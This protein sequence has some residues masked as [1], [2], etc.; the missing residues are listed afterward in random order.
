APYREPV[1]GGKAALYVENG[2]Y[3]Y[4]RDGEAPKPVGI[5]YNVEFSPDRTR[6]VTYGKTGP[7]QWVD[8]TTGETQQLDGPGYYASGVFDSW[9]PDSSLYLVQ[10]FRDN[11]LPGFHFFGRDGKP[12]WTWHEP[13]YLSD[14]AFWSPGASKIAFLST[15]LDLKYKMPPDAWDEPPMAPRLG[16]LDLKT[17]TAKYFQ[18]DGQVAAGWPLWAPDGKQ[19]ALRFG[20]LQDRAGSPDVLRGQ[21]YVVDVV[22]GN[23]RPVTPPPTE[24]ALQDVRAWSPDSTALLIND[25]GLSLQTDGSAGVIYRRQFAVDIRSGQ[26]AL[27]PEYAKWV[28]KDRIVVADTNGTV[29]LVDRQGKD[30]QALGYGN[31]PVI[32]PTGS[33][34]PSSG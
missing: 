24:D 21:I 34:R 17:R 6:L 30:L 15:P 32:S 7:G 33:G 10:A 26:Q 28:D 31:L 12:A 19:I 2:T 14:W 4:Q 3:M 16:V 1:A 11:P 22:S 23:L 8:L 13:G 18:V 29:T 27:L 20:P 5:A 9:A 25:T